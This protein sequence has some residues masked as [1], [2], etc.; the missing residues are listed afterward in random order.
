MDVNN[1]FAEVFNNIYAYMQVYKWGERQKF[2]VLYGNWQSNSCNCLTVEQF[3]SVAALFNDVFSFVG[4]DVAASVLSYECTKRK[5]YNLVKL[6]VSSDFTITKAVWDIIYMLCDKDESQ[7]NQSENAQII[8]LFFCMLAVYIVDTNIVIDKPDTCIYETTDAYPTKLK[9]A[10]PCLH[11]LIKYKLNQECDL[12]SCVNHC[13]KELCNT[14]DMG[15]FADTVDEFAKTC[16]KCC[17]HVADRLKLLFHL[18]E[19]AQE[20]IK[21][22]NRPIWCDV[23]NKSFI[24]FIKVVC[25]YT[26]GQRNDMDSIPKQCYDD[27]ATQEKLKIQGNNKDKNAVLET[28]Q[29]EINGTTG[30]V[31]NEESVTSAVNGSENEDTDIPEAACAEQAESAGMDV[32]ESV[33]VFN[34]NVGVDGADDESEGG[35]PAMGDT[36]NSNDAITAGPVSKPQ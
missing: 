21:M 32:N 28:M 27:S 36:G 24:D 2:C 4:T 26:A 17:M 22:F 6:P 19:Q 15:V 14:F 30:D 12:H 3:E 9:N 13:I 34:G 10:L 25:W 29:A 33:N 8:L 31:L 16:S 23:L 1:K 35:G 18:Y 5:N 11:A 7:F 20:F